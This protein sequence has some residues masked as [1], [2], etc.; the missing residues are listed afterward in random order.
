MPEY[1]L[2]NHYGLS[3]SIAALLIGAGYRTPAEIRVLSDETLLAIDDIDQSA[4]DAIRAA[5]GAQ[6]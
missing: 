6:I 1:K 4:V 2:T 5:L 3:E